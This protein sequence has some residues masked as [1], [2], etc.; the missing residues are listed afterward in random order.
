MKSITTFTIFLIILLCS[1]NVNS[2]T[3]ITEPEDMN[4]ESDSGIFHSIGD[5]F[6]FAYN[7]DISANLSYVTGDGSATTLFLHKGFSDNFGLTVGTANSDFYNPEILY[8]SPSFNVRAADN[9][10]VGLEL[11]TGYSIDASQTLMSPTLQISFGS[12]E[13]HFSVGYSFA[14]DF[15]EFESMALIDGLYLDSSVKFGGRIP[16]IDNVAIVSRNQYLNIDSFGGSASAIISRT[17]IDFQV[18]S[19][20]IQLMIFYARVSSGGNSESDEQGVI[21]VSYQF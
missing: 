8:I 12:I 18:S 11:R 4:D 16:I 1:F 10:H 6:A 20:S 9:I 2:Q 21:G 7:E 15:E 13:K 3:V 14:T 17:G 5:N 19:F